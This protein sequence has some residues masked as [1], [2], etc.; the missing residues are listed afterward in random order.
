M[1]WSL[2][3]IKYR[4]L[5]GIIC[6]S[7]LLYLIVLMLL[8]KYAMGVNPGAFMY[9]PLFDDEPPM[10]KIARQLWWLVGAGGFIVILLFIR[11]VWKDQDHW[12]RRLVKWWEKV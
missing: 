10:A 11:E 5:R 9:N 1:G 6:I 4:R 8:I 3:E 2:T 7:L 12:L